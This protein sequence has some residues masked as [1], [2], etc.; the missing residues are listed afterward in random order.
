MLLEY[1][2]RNILNGKKCGVT[3]LIFELSA[4]ELE[5][6]VKFKGR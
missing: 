4:L 5:I 2:N 3:V 6:F 1:D